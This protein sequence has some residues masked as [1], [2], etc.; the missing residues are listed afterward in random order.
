MDKSAH[1]SDSTRRFDA[2][3][4]DMDGTLDDSEPVHCLAYGKVL[5]RFGKTHSDEDYNSRFTGATDKFIAT[6][7][8]AEHTLPI[9]VDAFLSEKE[10]LFIELVDGHAVALPGVI[11]TLEA[12]RAQ[13]V[14][15]ASMEEFDS[16][17]VLF[18]ET[19]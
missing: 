11:K 5:A 15:L 1:Q 16:H 3:C 10:A 8:I 6:S 19:A 12:L 7:L 9:S 2:A 13:G 17:A 14:K 18:G 4:F